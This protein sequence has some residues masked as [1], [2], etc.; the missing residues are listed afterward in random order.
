MGINKFIRLLKMFA[1]EHFGHDFI[2]MGDRFICK[3]CGA[4]TVPNYHEVLDKNRK[5]L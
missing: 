5:K 1:C 4:I 2:K 3:R